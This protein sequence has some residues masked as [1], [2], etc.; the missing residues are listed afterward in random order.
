MG[1]VEW[2][3]DDRAVALR[4]YRDTESVRSIARR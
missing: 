4:R 1:T 3:Y 2:N